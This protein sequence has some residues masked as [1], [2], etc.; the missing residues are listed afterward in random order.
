MS[1]PTDE[2]VSQRVEKNN[3]VGYENSGGALTAQE[4]LASKEDRSTW[5]TVFE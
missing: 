3:L 4:Q 5:R 1:P 2:R